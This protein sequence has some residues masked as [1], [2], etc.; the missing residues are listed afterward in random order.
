[1]H[2]PRPAPPDLRVVYL[3]SPR[4]RSPDLVALARMPPG[5]ITCHQ[6]WKAGKTMMWPA[7]PLVTRVLGRY[8]S[9]RAG[10]VV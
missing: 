6:P 8:R 5:N 9:G 2:L 10:V 1:M 7:R 3:D 4:E